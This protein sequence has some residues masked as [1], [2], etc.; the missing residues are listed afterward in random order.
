MAKRT[1]FTITGNIIMGIITFFMIMLF[2]SGVL[3]AILMG[4]KDAGV[5]INSIYAMIL[6]YTFLAG[7]ALWGYIWFY[8]DGS[9]RR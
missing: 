3:Y 4:V 6:G 2:G 7:F 8:L 5:D 1:I 9:R